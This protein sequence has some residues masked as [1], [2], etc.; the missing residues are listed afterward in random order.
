MGEMM[1]EVSKHLD[2][3]ALWLLSTT[4]LLHLLWH[5]MVADRARKVA[6]WDEEFRAYK[7]AFE[8]EA[9]RTWLK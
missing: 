2:T 4:V 9:R 8:E 5:R 1:Y 7:A 3:I 6:R